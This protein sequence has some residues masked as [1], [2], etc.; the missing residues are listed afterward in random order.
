MAKLPVSKTGLGGS[1]PSAPASLNTEIRS[2][3]R[4]ADHESLTKEWKHGNE[5]NGDGT[6]RRAFRQT[7]GARRIAGVFRQC[8]GQ[9][10]RTHALFERRACRNAQ[11][12]SARTEGSPGD[13]GGGHRNG[14]PLWHLF[15]T[16]RL[17]VW[18]CGHR[19]A[20]P[21]ERNAIG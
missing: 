21:T 15:L 9:M 3:D 16:D 10:E 1:N 13:H 6:K 18:P 7:A 17:C 14:V 8:D 19:Y 2:T 20:E 5:D 11:G 12:G 4:N